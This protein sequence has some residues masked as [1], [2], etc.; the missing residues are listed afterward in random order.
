MNSP[1]SINIYIAIGGNSALTAGG[2]VNQACPISALNSS[3]HKDWVKDGCQT[4]SEPMINNETLH[5]E[6]HS[7]SSGV[8]GG[9][10]SHIDN[11]LRNEA[12]MRTA[13]AKRIV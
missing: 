12:K 9:G 8:C 10:G 13:E 4:Q 6:R 3:G 7:Y 5:G 1:S 11:I 2:H